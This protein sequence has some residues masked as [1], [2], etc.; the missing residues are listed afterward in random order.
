MI[1]IA[2]LGNSHLENWKRAWNSLGK[3]YPDVELVFFAAPGKQL[4]CCEP[5]GD[6][7]VFKSE[8]VARWV[9]ITSGGRREL[10]TA[11]YDAFCVVG[12]GCG[13][14]V[15]TRLYSEWRADSHKGR[16]GR[17]QL[18]SDACFLDALGDLLKASPAMA[19]VGKLRQVTD[20]VIWL[21]P[22][23]ALSEIVLTLDKSPKGIEIAA[24]ATDA[25]SLRAA[26]DEAC[27]RLAAEDLIVLEQPKATLASPLLSKN[28]YRRT[29]LTKPDWMHLN[30]AYGKIVIRELLSSFQPSLDGPSAGD[31]SGSFLRLADPILGVVRGKF[32]QLSTRGTSKS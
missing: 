7:I 30:D 6:R 1:R 18:I 25:P 4:E 20:K 23:P 28:E 16:E 2:L 17:F 29:N 9:E 22:T 14:S 27:R 11:D 19:L 26:Y 5:Q 32:S 12:L 24:A 3:A 13:V 21:A 15:V 8:D 31:S 10:V